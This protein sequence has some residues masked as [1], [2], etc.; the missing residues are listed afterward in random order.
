MKLGLRALKTNSLLDHL[1]VLSK[2]IGRLTGLI[3]GIYL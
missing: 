2:I 3:K 1:P